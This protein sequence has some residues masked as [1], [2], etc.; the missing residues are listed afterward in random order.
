MNK[1]KLKMWILA[2]ATT[3]IFVA[4]NS[5]GNNSQQLANQDEQTQTSHE[6]EPENNAD[7]LLSCEEKQQEFRRLLILLQNDE[8]TDSEFNRLLKLLEGD[9]IDNGQFL[10]FLGI[11]AEK[12]QKHE[13]NEVEPDEITEK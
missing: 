10:V 9:C 1:Q 12:K 8:N 3:L 7:S 4:Y 5:I 13:K 6:D 2:G 11:I